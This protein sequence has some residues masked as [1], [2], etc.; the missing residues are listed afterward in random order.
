MGTNGTVLNQTKLQKV[1]SKA[2][3][4]VYE[5]KKNDQAPINITNVYDFWCDATHV[6]HCEAAF[7]LQR[8]CREPLE[9]LN[10]PTLNPA[11]S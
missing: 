3:P 11:D 2:L 5:E 8:Q 7:R 1:I 6:K 4:H 10:S 9:K